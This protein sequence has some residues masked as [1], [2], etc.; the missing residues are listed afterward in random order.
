MSWTLTQPPDWSPDAIATS[1]GWVDPVTGELIVAIRGLNVK[2]DAPRIVRV[3]R[4]GSTTKYGRSTTISF[5]VKFN[6]VVVV[7]GT[8]R[9]PLSIGAT[10]GLYLLYVSGSGSSTLVF[11]YAVQNTQN[12]AVVVESPIGLNSGTI[13]DALDTAAVLT[14]TAPNTTG[15]TVDTTLPTTTSAAAISPTAFVTGDTINVVVTFSEAVEVVGSPRLTLDLNGTPAYAVYSSGSGSTALTFSYTVA[16]EDSV[17]AGDFA[18]GSQ[19]V[20]LNGGTIKDLSGNAPTDIT[21]TGPSNVADISVNSTAAPV[22]SSVTFDS[23]DAPYSVAK[24]SVLTLTAHMSKA[25]V[26]TGSPRLT[27]AIDGVAKNAT[28]VS[29]SGTKDLVFQY[30][31]VSGDS[32]ATTD[33]DVSSPLVLNGGTIKDI[34]DTAATPLTFTPPDTDAVVID[35]T[36][37]TAP[38]VTGPSAATYN[39]GDVLTFTATYSDTSVVVTGSPLLPITINGVARNAVFD[40]VVDGALTFKYTVVSGDSATSGQIVVVSPITLNGGT[41]KDDAGNSAVIT[42]TPPTLTGRIIDN[43]PPT[44]SSVAAPTGHTANAFSTGN[45]LSIVVTFSEA[46]TVTGTPRILLNINGVAKY[47]TYASGSTTTA[48]TFTY[49]VVSGDVATAG[50]FALV[51]P[52]QLNS[53]TIVDGGGNSITVPALAFDLP[54]TA[55][56][57]FN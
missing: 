13:K 33:F 10:T 11:S 3:T 49:T 38:T 12:G 20:G 31:V 43:T 23:D 2:N 51:S 24:G 1:A 27:L 5:R 22:I 26:V 34:Y 30:T 55:L 48:L 50:Q 28:Y 25:C 18:M 39:A 42:F 57:T 16:E 52:L 47:A 45:T 35:N 56:M 4:V 32:C 9:I 14:F 7:T 54:S 37:P 41:I 36:G 19:D 44:I 53:G 46:V 6:E 40:E 17:D 29:G 21:F 15:V 8:P